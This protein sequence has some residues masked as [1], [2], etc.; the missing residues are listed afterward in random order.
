MKHS[1]EELKAIAYQYFPRDLEGSDTAYEHTEEY[2]RRQAAR[3]RASGD[4]EVW[5]RMLDR[6]EARF[7]SELHANVLV[8]NLCYFLESP[9]AGPSDRCFSGALWLATR[10]SE[11]KQHKLGFLV[12]FVV[13][14]YVVYSNTLVSLQQP[15]AERDSERVIGFQLSPDEAP[16]ARGLAEEIEA[17]FPGYQPMLPE[18]GKVILPDIDDLHE[19][20]QVTIFDCLFTDHW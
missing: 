9:T 8:E 20:G 1:I 3:A 11:E 17:A 5:S 4:Y 16:F 6:I 12:S 18:V 2:R 10:A 13:P 7:P 15:A 14:Y 19:L